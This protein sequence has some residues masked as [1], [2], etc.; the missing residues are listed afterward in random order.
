MREDVLILSHLSLWIKIM[1]ANIMN[2]ICMKVLLTQWKK[3]QSNFISNLKWKDIFII[4]KI[5]K[6]IIKLIKSTYKIK[7]YVFKK[8]NPIWKI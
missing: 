3:F 7:E 2:I 5:Y 4:F 8:I 6:W 1:F